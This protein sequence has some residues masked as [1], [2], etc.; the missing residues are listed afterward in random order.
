M[1]KNNSIAEKHDVVLRGP[2]YQ[3]NTTY[4][5]GITEL[6]GSTGIRC[7]NGICTGQLYTAENKC[8]SPSMYRDYC[9]IAD[10]SETKN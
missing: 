3:P 9:E 7:L 1:L 6:L 10:T 2:S 4:D 8:S 5:F